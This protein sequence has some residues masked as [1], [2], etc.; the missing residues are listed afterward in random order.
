MSV[1]GGEPSQ[2]ASERE[3]DPPASDTPAP[4]PAG[5][6]AG[7]AGETAGAAGEPAATAGA[8]TSQRTISRNRLVWVDVLIW[9]TT[10]LAV[11][12]V[13]AAW[14]T[15]AV[16][17][18]NWSNT[19]TQLL[20]DAKIRSAT[21][22]YAVDQLYANYDVA[23]LIKSG[24]PPRLQ[25]LAGPASGALRNLAVQAT[26]LALSRPVIQALW[27]RAN[28]AAAQTLVAI[29]NGQKG[30]VQFNQ[31]RV[32]LDLASIVD[33]VA[34]RLGL[35]SDI[36]SKLPPSVAHLV[37]F[38]SDQLKLVQNGGKALKGL[39]LLLTIIVPLLYALAIFLARGH[40]RRTLMTVGFAGVV[41]GVI[42][43]LGR[44]IM[45]SQVTPAL[46]ADESI[47]PAVHDVVS[48]ATSMLSQVASAVLIGGLVLAAAAYFAGPS[49]AMTA[50]RRA[51]TPFLR[52]HPDRS[53][54]LVAAVMAL[55]FIWQPFHATST[56]AG[57][58]VFFVLAMF[59]TW[60][61]RRQVIQE[62]P[63]ARSGATTA[64]LRERAQA[65][66]ERRHHRARQ[67]AGN[68]NG[69]VSD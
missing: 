24:L 26:E 56:P 21:A 66:R 64:A 3:P 9:V 62:F 15:A 49:R 36:S 41:A 32:T 4:P 20:Q 44:H 55:I 5:A 42:V 46:A 50:A 47:R 61:L 40:R 45:I 19:S 23:A 54:G 35:P 25:P 2:P 53:F 51:I 8:T 22:N 52:D 65:F 68:G 12:G 16:G 48:I 11:I 7:S 1:S 43:L 31:G 17:P 28:R 10:V 18:H 6:D 59:G 27:S 69:A 29:V 33:Q 39:A 57:I 58:I 63:D 13:F 14:A 30:A 38:K 34:S 60:V 67:V 37:V